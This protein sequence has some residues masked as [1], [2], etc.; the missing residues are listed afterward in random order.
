MNLLVCSFEAFSP[1][2]DEALFL[3]LVIITVHLCMRTV[4]HFLSKLDLIHV[5]ILDK[6]FYRLFYVCI[7]DCCLLVTVRLS[8][9]KPHSCRVGLIYLFV[10]LLVYYIMSDCGVT[11]D[12]HRQCKQSG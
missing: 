8:R 9:C 12:T 5:I 4:C 2:C 10:Y 7:D 3:K 11:C 6:I 1:F